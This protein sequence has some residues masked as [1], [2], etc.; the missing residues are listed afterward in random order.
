M[1][2][3]ME[4]RTLSYRIQDRPLRYGET[5]A[6]KWRTEMSITAAFQ[7]LTAVHTFFS[8]ASL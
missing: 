3:G 5:Y 2:F 6:A 1:S 7:T 8:A 4:R